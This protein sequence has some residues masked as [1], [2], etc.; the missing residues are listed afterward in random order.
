MCVFEFSCSAFNAL[1]IRPSCIGNLWHILVNKMVK[2]LK[3]AA[4]EHLWV[5]CVGLRWMLNEVTSSKHCCWQILLT[6]TEHQVL[7]RNGDVCFVCDWILHL[8]G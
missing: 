1:I 5:R 4:A 3:E 6:Q 2:S 8:I 7:V